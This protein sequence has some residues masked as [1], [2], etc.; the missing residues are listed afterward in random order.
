MEEAIGLLDTLSPSSRL[1]ELLVDGRKSA[2]QP[3]YT[4]H[5]NS[6]ENILF[7]QNFGKLHCLSLSGDLDLD[8][9]LWGQLTSRG[10]TLTNDV[11]RG[12]GSFF[13]NRRRR[14]Y[15][16]SSSCSFVYKPGRTLV[17]IILGSLLIGCTAC[18][19]STLVCPH[20]TTMSL[21]S[22]TFSCSLC[23]L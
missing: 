17:I 13:D 6:F 18:I 12:F 22:L 11:Y 7:R 1:E 15:S 21:F 4:R 14:N 16:M 20:W 19:S 10:I 9:I 2:A 8:P 5:W 3:L 23:S